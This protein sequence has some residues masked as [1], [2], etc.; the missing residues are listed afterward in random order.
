MRV[1]HRGDLICERSGKLLSLCNE[2]ESGGKDFRHIAT[3]S[4]SNKGMGDN[5]L[6]LNFKR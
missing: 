2:S 4:I 6:Q 1:P 3:E 5:R